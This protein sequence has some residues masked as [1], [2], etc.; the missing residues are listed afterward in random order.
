MLQ[1]HLL[2]HHTPFFPQRGQNGHFWQ[3]A[4]VISPSQAQARHSKAAA[5]AAS[6]RPF[7]PPHPGPAQQGRAAPIPTAEASPQLSRAQNTGQQRAL[8]TGPFIICHNYYLPTEG[9][10][11]AE[12]PPRGCGLT[13]ARPHRAPLSHRPA[14]ASRGYCACAATAGPSPSLPRRSPA[15]PLRRN[16]WVEV[17]VG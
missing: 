12:R 16:V 13:A 3:G 8:G 14:S 17:N 15:V 7:P 6:P 9:R 2:N 11:A 5:E 10:A 4:G 1:F